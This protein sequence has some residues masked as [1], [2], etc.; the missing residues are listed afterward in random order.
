MLCKVTNSYL[1]TFLIERSIFM[2]YVVWCGSN[3]E[4]QKHTCFK[5]FGIRAQ[6]MITILI[7][8]VHCLKFEK[9]CYLQLVPVKNEFSANIKREVFG[10]V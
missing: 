3:N 4:F 5:E 10:F 7:S 8:I 6:N 1:V 2:W 9:C